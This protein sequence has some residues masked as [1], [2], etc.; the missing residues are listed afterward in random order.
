MG[1]VGRPD[2]MGSVVAFLCSEGA[3]YLSGETIRV[4]GGAS[5]NLF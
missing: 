4:D 3:S 5:R 2:E 1:R